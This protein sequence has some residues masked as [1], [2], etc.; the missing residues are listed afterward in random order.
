M[1]K[2]LVREEEKPHRDEMHLLEF[3][4][5]VIADRVPIDP[6]TG[7]ETTEII[8]ERTIT[9]QGQPRQQKW[10]ARGDPN[11][12]GLPRGFDLDVFTALMTQWGK[13]DFQ[14]RIISL[15]SIYSI[16]KM[17]GKSD[18]G[19]NYRRFHRAIDRLFGLSFEAQYSIWDPKAQHRI[20]R[21]RFKLLSSDVLKST[22]G[23]EAPR[24]IVR[25]TEEFCHLIA[26]GYLKCT[27]IE[28]Y[29]RLPTTYSRR[30]FQYLD[31]HRS[32]ALRER[33]GRFEINGFL[34]AKKLGTL[35]QTIHSYRPAKLRDVMAP[36]L[37]AL[38][39]DGYLAEYRWKREGRGRAPV[40]LE[41]AYTPTAAK[42]PRDRVLSD[43]ELAAILDISR[44]LGEP[45]SQP[46]IGHVVREIGP[47]KAR[48]I[49][50]DVIARSE[51]DP[52]TH[53]G[54]LF[55]YLSEQQRHPRRRA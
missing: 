24:G 34:L 6:A 48:Q 47:A 7:L 15:G 4:M 49:L 35:D 1:N 46:Y 50:T 53:K 11:Y 45:E 51:A 55:T 20:P 10:I 23:A 27:D 40:V 39:A 18:Q 5:G 22:D 31:K 37:D 3:P 38:V 33:A 30:L 32:R 14:H 43:A 41:A 54:K 28:R 13:S 2:K 19:G 9:E 12:G 52:K 29:W 36:H 21:F 26:L 44:L 16:L 17:G 25:V 8:V 42:A